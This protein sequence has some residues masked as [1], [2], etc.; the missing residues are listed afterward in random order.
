MYYSIQFAIVFAF[1]NL[2]ISYTVNNLNLIQL[3]KEKKD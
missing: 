3:N 2:Y 1:T